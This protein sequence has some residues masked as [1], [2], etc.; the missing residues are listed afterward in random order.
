MFCKAF[1]GKIKVNHKNAT[2]I[3]SKK[4]IHLHLSLFSLS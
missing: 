3:G 4:S 1:E 2:F